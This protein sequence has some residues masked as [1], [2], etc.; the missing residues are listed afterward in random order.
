MRCGDLAHAV[1]DNRIRLKTRKGDAIH[2][3][4][5]TFKQVMWYSYFDDAAK[6]M[7]ISVEKVKEIIDLNKKGK[8]PKELEAY[9]IVEEQKGHVESDGVDD[10][11]AFI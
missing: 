3:K 2:Q 11:A 9:A 7:A 4:S 8:F 1:P 5:D 6:M 10:F